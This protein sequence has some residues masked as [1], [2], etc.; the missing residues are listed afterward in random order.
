MSK[1]KLKKGDEVLVLTGKDKG[2]KGRILEVVPDKAKAIVEGINISIKA[3]KANP[4][5]NITGGLVEKA[6][7]IHV[8]NLMLIDAATSKPGRAAFNVDA[9]T[10]NKVRVVKPGKRKVTR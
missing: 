3:T 8:S 1:I 6:M 10:G 5:K 9:A 2:R 7:P 4:Q